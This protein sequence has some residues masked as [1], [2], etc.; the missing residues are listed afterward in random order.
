MPIGP[1]QVRTPAPRRAPLRLG[2]VPLIHAAPLFAAAEL[3][4]FRARGLEVRLCRELGW[5]TIRDKILSGELEAAQALGPMP[6]ALT[7]GIGSVRCPALTA[8]VLN[9][10][11]NALIVARRLWMA[12]LH[13]DVPLAQLARRREEPLTFAIV[14]AHSSH[15]FLLKRWLGHQG[16]AEGRDFR[17]VVVPPSQMVH[18]LRA[19]H[20]D[21]GCVGEPWGTLAVQAGVGVIIALSAE[22]APDHPE[23][24]LVVREVFAES[25]HAEHLALVAAL[26][27]ACAWC[28]VPANRPALLD[29]LADR[30]GLE[31]PRAA[32]EPVL[33]GDYDLGA[34]RR[35]HQPEAIIFNGDDV[36]EPG[37]RHARWIAGCLDT[38]EAAAATLLQ[39]TF[40]ADLYRDALSLPVSSRHSQPAP[41]LETHLS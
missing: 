39:R 23:K 6:L 7:L 37:L 29:L 30:A 38:P 40:R 10:H 41:T 2:Y 16:L 26:R 13:E 34:C 25:R 33:T 4:L 8:L 36:N 1:A 18:H 11:G 5:A 35:A 15:A 27:E 32:L 17:L 24:V 19:G 31:V 3:G 14:H 22:L 9:V 21:G 20:V 12:G 28:A